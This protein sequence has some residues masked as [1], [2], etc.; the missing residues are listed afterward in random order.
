MTEMPYTWQ[1]N[2]VA[3]LMDILRWCD[4]HLAADDWLHSWETVRFRHAR[5]FEC[6]LLRWT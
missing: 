3:P 5:D 6:F 1:Y 2:G 4:S